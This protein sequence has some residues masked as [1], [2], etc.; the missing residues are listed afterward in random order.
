MARFEARLVV[1]T[2]AG[3]GIGG[4]EHFA[5]SGAT[6]I[7]ADIDPATARE[8]ALRITQRSGRADVHAFDVADPQAW[9]AFGADR[10]PRLDESRTS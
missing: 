5:A 1:V 4:A 10:T 6:V 8:T 3:S 2:G 7:C 9:D